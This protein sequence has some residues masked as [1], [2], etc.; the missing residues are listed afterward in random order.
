[1]G[2]S[3]SL[4]TPFG[5]AFAVLA[6]VLLVSCTQADTPTTEDTR[7]STDQTPAAVPES[8]PMG[9]ARSVM[10][11]FITSEGPGRGGDLGGLDGA[12]AHCQ[13]LAKAEGAGDHLWRAHLST[14]ATDSEPAVNAR[15]RIGRGPWYNAEGL[16]IAATLDDLYGDGNRITKRLA[17]TER[18]D[19]VGGVGDSPNR[20]D[21][22]TGSRPDGTAYPASDRLTCRNWTSSSE[23]RAQVGHHD[24]RYGDG[25][26]RSSLA[27]WNSDHAS[28]GCSQQD[29]E[30]TGGAGLFYCFAAD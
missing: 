6:G 16:L 1:M 10:S 3:R 17:V 29:L 20:H 19:E 30:A 15:D 4:G 22:L 9:G 12:D 27:S 8:L 11:F 26:E 25:S 14:S 5:T 21:I 7:E 24:R 28:G 13:A 18:L 23:G 2:R